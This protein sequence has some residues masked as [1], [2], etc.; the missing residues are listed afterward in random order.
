MIDQHDSKLVYTCAEFSEK[1]AII[2]YNITL[3]NV[4]FHLMKINLL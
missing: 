3:F 1:L 4:I 2:E